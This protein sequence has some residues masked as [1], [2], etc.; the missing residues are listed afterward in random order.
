[1]C[2]RKRSTK[3]LSSVNAPIRRTFIPSSIEK[4]MQ[5]D[6]LGCES[7]GARSLACLVKTGERTVLIDP[8]VALARLRSGL[9]PTR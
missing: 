8:G 1:M 6:I 7:F 5:I 3:L 2:R 4:H 9:F